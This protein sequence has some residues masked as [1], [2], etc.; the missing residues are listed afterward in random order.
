MRVQFEIMWESIC[1]HHIY[2]R[3]YNRA[4]RPTE[5]DGIVALLDGYDAL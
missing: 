1:Q 5:L 2:S 3:T 4:S